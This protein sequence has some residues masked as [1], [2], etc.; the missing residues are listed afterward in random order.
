MR[1]E[2]KELASWDSEAFSARDERKKRQSIYSG[3]TLG[4][5]RHKQ[6]CL[7]RRS[8]VGGWSED[9]FTAVGPS[10]PEVL[11]ASAVCMLG[12]DPSSP[13]ALSA[14][15]RRWLCLQELWGKQMLKGGR[16]WR[17]RQRWAEKYID[18]EYLPKKRQ[19]NQPIN[20]SGMR[21]LLQCCGNEST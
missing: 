8:M 10:A 2:T 21:H 19:T 5:F 13:W 17:R 18:H 4:I 3:E 16:C 14:P 15:A 7:E 12:T 20:G 1:L 11:E 9:V 6:N